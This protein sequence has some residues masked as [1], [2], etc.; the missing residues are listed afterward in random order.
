MAS[1]GL[2]EIITTTLRNRRKTFANGVE[3]N[4]PVLRSMKEHGTFEMEDGGRTLVDPVMFDQNGTFTR[5]TGGQPLNLSYNDTQTAFEVD[6]KQ[7]SVAITITG[8]EERMNSGEFALKKLIKQRM[9]VAEY[10]GENYFNADLISDGTSDGGLQMGGL[11]YWITDTPTSGTKGGIDVSTGTVFQN[12]KYATASDTFA[13]STGATTSSNIKARLNYCVNKTTRGA[14][15]VKIM[16]AGQSMF[17][18]LQAANDSIVR[19]IQESE[20]ARTGFTQLYHMGIPVYMCGGVNFGGQTQLATDRIYGVNTKF[21]KVR[22]HKDAYFEPLEDLQAIN[23][24]T[25]AQI[26]VLMANM[27]CA[28][29]ALNFV[30]Y[31]S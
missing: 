23:A 25:R 7:S 29:P 22:I 15:T 24:D 20:V 16:L 28:C 31:D 18:A 13:G 9:Q 19:V 3:N 4:N 10:T 17:E 11:K 8:R 5:Y 21:T 1:P 6:W 30:I 14:D 2:S 27:T 12:L 26:I